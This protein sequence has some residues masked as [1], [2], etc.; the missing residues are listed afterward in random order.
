MV[1]LY[2]APGVVA[3]VWVMVAYWLWSWD[4]YCRAWSLEWPGEVM[5]ILPLVR[6]HGLRELVSK[7]PLMRRFPVDVQAVDEGVDEVLVVVAAVEPKAL[8][9]AKSVGEAAVVMLDTE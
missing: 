8:V 4:W 3:T 1:K 7:S 5:V 6:F 9:V 2:L